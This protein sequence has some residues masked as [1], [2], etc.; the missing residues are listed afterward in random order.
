MIFNYR[1][2]NSQGAYQEGQF[3]GGSKEELMEMLRGNNL[4]PVEINQDITAGRTVKKGAG[5]FKTKDLSIFCR[6]FATMLQAGIGIVKCL[7]IL[8][9]QSTHQGLKQACGEMMTSV[10]KGNLLSNAM[11]EHKNLFPQLLIQMVVAGE[12][13]GNLDVVMDR[14]AMTY[15]KEAKIENK[16]GTAMIYPIVLLVV[17]MVVVTFILIVVMPKFVGVFEA[18]NQELP[19]STMFLLGASDFLVERWYIVLGVIVVIIVLIKQALSKDEGRRAFDSFKLKAPLIGPQFKMIVTSR[20]TRTLATLLSSGIGLLEAISIVGRVVGNKE[21]EHRL[22]DA[23]EDIK[24]GVALSRAI[25]DVDVFPPMVVSM[26]KIGEESGSLDTVLEKT[27]DYYD[28]ELD[29]AIQRLVGLMEPAMIAFLGV[30][31]AFIV[32]SIALPMFGMYSMY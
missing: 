6:Q 2:I 23:S 10:Q 1:A 14:L 27:A 30:V 8:E 29:T 11:A 7:D 20:F 15:E 32:I 19:W 4:I 26:L 13:S 31:V 25:S 21:V 17:M 22:S 28:E 24:K 3:E 12:A 18:N 5:K 9:K 16:M